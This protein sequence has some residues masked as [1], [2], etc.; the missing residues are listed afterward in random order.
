MFKRK[1]RQLFVDTKVQGT[2]I[3]H[4]FLYWAFCLLSVTLMLLCYRISTGPVQ[5]FFLH[6]RE[7]WKQFAPALMASTL[8][9]PIVVIDCIRLS[10]KFAGPIFRLRH[11]M[12]QLAQGETLRSIR[13]REKDFWHEMA[14][15]FNQLLERLQAAERK[16]AEQEERLELTGAER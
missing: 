15:D 9:L 4:A 7:L 6:A 13:F 12:H 8:L 3:L 2:L 1:R 11:S 10:N 14:D 16:L 5:P